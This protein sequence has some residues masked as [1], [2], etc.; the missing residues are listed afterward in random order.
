MFRRPEIASLSLT[1]IPAYSA[2]QAPDDSEQTM[3]R[4]MMPFLAAMVALGTAAADEPIVRRGASRAAG[5]LP[6]GPPRAHYKNRTTASPPPPAPL[7][8]FP[9]YAPP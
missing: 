7:P 4:W 9:P 2:I 1:F 3:L 6:A 5:Q 8:L